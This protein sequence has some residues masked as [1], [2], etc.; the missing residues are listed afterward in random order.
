MLTKEQVEQYFE[1]RLPD[2]RLNFN[3]KN[4]PAKCPFHDDREASL[5]IHSES[6][7]WK[8][9]GCGK[10]G[11]VLDFEKFL[12]GTPEAVAELLGISSEKIPQAIYTYTDAF[13]HL[14]FEK[15]RFPGKKFLSRRR[16]GDKWVWNL[17]GIEDKPIYQLKRVIVARF[18]F[19]CNGEKAAD[20]LN[21]A[22][23]KAGKLDCAATSTYDGE[24]KWK[25]RDS[26]WFAGKA[27]SVFP[28]NDEVGRA[29]ASRV[30]ESVAKVAHLVKVVPLE[31]P[32]KG[33]VYD[34]LEE[35]PLEDL[36][37]AV[38][39]APQ[40]RI[41]QEMKKHLFVSAED[42]MGRR[43]AHSIDWAVEGVVQRGGNGMILALPGAGKSYA[44]LDLS[45]SLAC[46][47]PFLGINV[48]NK[49]RVAYMAREDHPELTRWRLR[50]LWLG[51]GATGSL[52]NLYLN[53]KEDMPQFALDND[54]YM[55]PVMEELDLFRPDFIFIDVLK[56][57]HGCEENDNTAM[58]KVMQQV[59]NMT[60]RLNCSACVVHHQG[61]AGRGGSLKQ[62]SRGASAIGGWPEWVMAMNIVNPEDPQKE[63]VRRVEFETKIAAPHD[64]VD[65]VIWSEKEDGP[66]SLKTVREDKVIRPAEKPSQLPL[67]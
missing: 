19:I 53:T 67:Q 42:F 17:N 8:C 45:I 36:L 43:S 16:E 13:G 51:K 37:E 57:V 18:V 40:F 21:E 50:H 58:N 44:A 41:Q 9:H 61:Y 5:S 66:I 11:S 27:V 31:V 7:R 10:R 34:Y 28:D 60:T 4:L 20:A 54:E 52:D 22:F 62:R 56:V 35:H 49:L 6:G 1:S 25:D 29:H 26:K 12:G 2:Q 38:K 15:I 33:D 55:I 39:L 23:D 30:A 47:L 65:F 32:E 24:G 48:P 14:I 46:G 59:T 63:W 64:P 3:L